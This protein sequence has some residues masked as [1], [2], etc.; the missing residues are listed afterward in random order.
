MITFY[1]KS[2]DKSYLNVFG[3]VRLRNEL[4]ELRRKLGSEWYEKLNEIEEFIASTNNLQTNELHVGD[5]MVC[6]T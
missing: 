4:H 5:T 3:K 6:T 1:F 2:G